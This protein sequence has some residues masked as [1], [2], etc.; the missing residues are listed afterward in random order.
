M[1]TAL[2]SPSSTPV[3][4]PVS[5]DRF[6]DA[7][8]VFGMAL[9]V[10]Q[11]WTMPVLTYDGT[12]LS[13]GNA[14]STPGAWL[15]TWISQVMP[16]VF[17]A[18]GAANAMSWGSGRS[19]APGWIASRL[20]RL[21]WPVLPL[22]AL[23][24][25]LPH[26]ALELGLPAQPVQ[27]ASGLVGQLL[28]FLAVYLIAVV[29]TPLMARLH[30]R[31]GL[32]V[33]LVLALCAPLVD[34]VRFTGFEQAGYL[35][36]VFVWL[37]VHQLGFLY[38]DGRLDRFTGRAGLPVAVAGFGV[39]AALVALGPYPA[40]M[41][42]MPGAAVSNMSPPTACMFALSVGQLALALALRPAIVRLSERPAVGALLDAAAPRMM[43]IYLWHMTALV[44]VAAVAVVGIGLVT[45]APF[46]AVWWADLPV[47]LG[48]LALV[49]GVLLRAFA[50][51]EN[52]P[53]AAG[54]PSA[55][56]VAAA[57]VLIGG[58]L[59]CLTVTGFRPGAT[60]MLAVGALLAGLWLAGGRRPAPAPAAPA[61]AVPVPAVPVPAPAVPASAPAV[62]A[63]V[64]LK[65]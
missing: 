42:G 51:F 16:L 30:D 7:L 46:G 21:A 9:V 43:T 48:V 22:A 45:P 62:P 53:R 4:A 18:G 50:R 17:F 41:I 3:R 10:V 38:R 32:A 27:F 1:T 44:L 29:S 14:F 33:P 13:A 54:V 47:W 23:W 40:S 57:T 58:A 11:H 65:R 2:L 52:P 6:I 60:P 37:A 28:W 55:R 35:N 19:A 34:V 63:P 56:A 12:R 49:L 26:L 64:L 31:F 59:L 5:R 36:V 39:V 8:R 61:P 25:P 20:R 15:I 24:L